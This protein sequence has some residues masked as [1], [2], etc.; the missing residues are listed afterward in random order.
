VPVPIERIAVTVDFRPWARVRIED[1]DGADVG[2]V[3]VTPF[4]VS[5]PPGRYVLHAENGGVTDAVQV[6]IEVRA[7]EA[8]VVNEVMPGF[9]ADRLVDRLIG[10]AP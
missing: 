9:D 4:V 10:P 1:T 8:L 2:D 6:P 5:L 7:D 3:S